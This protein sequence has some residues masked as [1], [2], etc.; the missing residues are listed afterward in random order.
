VISPPE[1]TRDHPCAHYDHPFV[2]ALSVE[3]S[4]AFGEKFAEVLRSRVPAGAA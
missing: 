4:Q 3:S 1:T 2:T